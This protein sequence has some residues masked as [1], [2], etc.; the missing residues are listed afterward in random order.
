MSNLN[1][2]T[3][4]GNLTRD[5]E[6]RVTQNGKSI[7]SFDIAVNEQVKNPSTGDWE[8]R[9]NYFNCVMFGDRVNKI[10]Q[11]LTKGL[12]VGIIGHLRYNSWEKDGEK[13]SRV[14]I[15]VDKLEFLTPK[16]VVS[17]DNLPNADIEDQLYDEDVLF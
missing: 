13:K 15:I 17:Q 9:T 14:Q 11:Y 10:Q 5:L 3:I 4:T 16:S 1:S 7:G 12:K 2:V 6:I 8:Q